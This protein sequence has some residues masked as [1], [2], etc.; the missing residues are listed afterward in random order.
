MIQRNKKNSDPSLPPPSPLS[1]PLLLPSLTVVRVLPHVHRQQGRLPREAERGL[2]VGRLG[3]FEL[4]A[5]QHEPRPP[6][7]ELGGARR[8]EVFL[9]GVQAAQVAVDG[10]QQGAGRLG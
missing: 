8:G 1:S 4:A 10:G 3:D 2:G 7:P 5:L 9:E 6:R